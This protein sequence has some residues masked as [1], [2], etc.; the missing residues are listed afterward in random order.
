MTQIFKFGDGGDKITS[1]TTLYAKWA[2]G[3]PIDNLHFPDK[4][5]RNYVKQS[6]D[7][8]SDDALSD[9]EIANVTSIVVKSMD[10]SSL[11]G[12]EYFTALQ[13]LWC[14]SNQLTTLDLRNCPNLNNSNVRYDND[15]VT[16]ILYSDNITVSGLSTTTSTASPL[17]TSPLGKNHKSDPDTSILAVLP[18]F[19]FAESGTYIFTVS[20]D[21]TPPEDSS[22]LLLADSEDLTVWRV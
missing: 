19:T 16:E 4:K 8:N 3:V 13:G 1:D 11:Q 6:F 17:N 12:I 21:R 15:K 9:A 14:W 7:T 20:L 22:L 2:S 18:A 5:F 10:I